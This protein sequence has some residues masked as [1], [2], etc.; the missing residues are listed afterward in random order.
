MAGLCAAGRARQLGLD[1]VVLE[2]G[3]RP[4][5]SML[6]SSCVV[7]RHRTFEDFRAECSRGNPGLQRLVWER[8]DDGLAWLESLGAP[9]VA[10][11][12]GNPRTTGVR[13][14]PRGLTEV[15]VRAAGRIRPNTPL[16]STQPEPA[17]EGLVQ[18]AGRIRP[19]TPLASTQPEPAGEGLV[20]AAGDIRLNT[21]LASTQPEPGSDGPPIVLATGGFQGSKELVHRF[22]RPAGDLLLRA[23]RWSA[24]DGLTVALERGGALSDGLDEFYGRAMPA[25]PAVAT[26]DRFVALAQLY[27]R[28]ALVVDDAGEQFVHE[29]VSWSEV[30]L[31]Q[32]IARRPGARAWYLVD[33]AALAVRVRERTVAEM[34][35]AARAAGATVLGPGELPFEVPFAYRCAV[36][37]AAA[38][39]HTIGGIRVDARARVLREDGTALDGLYACGADVGGIASGGY[40]SGLAAALV[41]GLAA[42]EEAARA[43]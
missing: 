9:V 37:V 8:L 42:A 27:G 41:L 2:K 17:G 30:D 40:A 12:T 10:R 34:I 43:V 22:I 16:A 7:W 28:H 25:P 32:A 26:E 24:G 15:L 18:A 19:N 1:V 33:D 4:G 14:D 29:P 13:F 5:G 21:P 20:R 35:D 23:N 3:T 31:V 39:T 11:E 6:L 38:I 36:H